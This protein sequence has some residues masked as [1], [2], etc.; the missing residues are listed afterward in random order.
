MAEELNSALAGER[1]CGLLVAP[2][3]Y[4][5][6][7]G[8]A[9]PPRVS[10]LKRKLESKDVEEKVSAMRE[11]VLLMLA[12]E[13][14][15]SLLMHVIRFAVPCDDKELQKL[16]LFFWEV[17]DK[18][19]ADGKLLHEMI[20]VCNALRNN[21]I[22][23]NEY[24]RGATLRFLC[25]V[26]EAELLEPVVPAVKACLDYKH[27]YVRRYAVNALHH[28]YDN[29]EFLCP[30]APDVVYDLLMKE[31][32]ASCKRNA[33]IMLAHTA[34]DKAVDYLSEVL[35]QVG[36]MGETLQLT[37]VELVR[38]VCRSNPGERSRYIKAIF[39][40]LDATSPA[41]RYEAATTLISLSAAPTA[42][43]AA[44]GSFVEVLAKESDNN[45]KL[46]VLDRL[47]AIKRHYPKILQEQVMDVIR[48]LSAPSILIRRKTLELVLELINPKNVE[49]VV[50]ALKK[51]IQKTHATGADDAAE[52]YRA[53]LINAIHACAVKFPDIA[54]NVI[55]VLLDFLSD[56]STS[57]L[58][59]VLF[60]REVVHKYPDLRPQV[61]RSLISSVS[62]I[63]S[64]KV[65][66]TVLWILGEF[67]DSAADID[68]LFTELRSLLGPLPFISDEDSPEQVA[69]EQIQ[70]VPESKRAS[71]AA[72]RPQVLADGTYASQSAVSET[73]AGRG[74]AKSKAASLNLRNFILA[75]EFFVAAVL[76]VTLTKLVLKIR[77]LPEGEVTRSTQNLLTAEVLYILA[78]L[79]RVGHPSTPHVTNVIDPDSADRLEFCLR[80]LSLSEEQLAALGNVDLTELLV[81]D[82]RAALDTQL[83]SEE[84]GKKAASNK[85]SP[86]KEGG[87][88]LVLR[89]RAPADGGDAEEPVEI[90]A[91]CDDLIRINQ[92]RTQKVYGLEDIE[93]FDAGADLSKAT[94]AA[95]KAADAFGDSLSRVYQLT[96]FSDPLYAEAHVTVHQYDIV[97]DVIIINQTP[98]TLQSVTLELS[99][100]GDLKLVDRPAQTTIAPGG[101][102][103][104]RAAIKVSSTETGAIFGNIVYDIAGTGG[105][106]GDSNVVVLNDIHID[107]MD[108]I[109]QGW[110][111]ELA[112][113]TMWAEFEWEN[114]VAVNAQHMSVAGFLEMTSEAT[115]MACLSPSSALDGECGFLS[116]NLYARSAFGEDALANVSIEEQADG[117]V[118]GFVRIRAK[119]QGIALALGDRINARQRQATAEPA[120]T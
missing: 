119:T 115:N 13:P 67:C 62:Q 81:D 26:K 59:V 10:D 117:R 70:S 28:I 90:V 51:E 113:R 23:P 114:K 83:S 40:L 46:V 42:V 54:A 5:A 24:L 108:Y 9:G 39:S 53:A 120:S 45:V 87:R 98:A 101:R 43:R 21:L 6:G 55:H 91:D 65:A 86:A 47:Q 72:S 58:E 74:D 97:L 17:V 14:L 71:A 107:I 96:G 69:P 37:V 99:T 84:A 92:L 63:T 29:F 68:E 112:F 85:A 104:V 33:F 64:G 16:L 61:L 82:T 48:A 25:K 106:G 2:E 95:E 3:A 73:A 22:H 94:G 31:G 56:S 102:T 52:E 44:T 111:T 38:H 105:A 30:D 1:A 36:N 19:G 78:N 18:T 109:S 32:D 77:R 20:L 88:R 118:T 7:V 41:V 57:G 11:I 12:G 93:D 4:S 116:A 34:K 60:V 50:L 103:E 89:S 8:D 49:E 66:R 75:G 79:L 110:C 76:G 27:A 80:V 100:L 15:Q 35:D